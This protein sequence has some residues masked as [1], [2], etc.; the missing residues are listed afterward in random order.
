MAT[1]FNNKT[2]MNKPL[3]VGSNKLG[4]LPLDARTRIETIDEMSMITFPYV[5]MMVYVK[6]EDKFYVVK[7]LK[8]EEIV[9]GIAATFTENYKIDQYEEFTSGASLDEEIIEILEILDKDAIESLGVPYKEATPEIPG[10]AIPEHY[11]KVTQGTPDSKQVVPDDYLYYNENLHV[12]QSDA[13]AKANP[14]ESFNVDDYVYLVG[15]VEGTETIPAQPEQEATG[16]FKTVMEMAAEASV[17]STDINVYGV[18]EIGGVKDGDVFAMGSTLEDVLKQ[19]FQ[20]IPTVEYQQPEIIL[21]LDPE[22]LE[23]EVGTEISPKINA[24]F[25]KHDAG[26]ETSRIYSPVNSQQQNSF[27]IIEGENSTSFGVTVNY[28]QGPQKTDTAGNNLGTPIQ[29]GYISASLNYVGYRNMFFGGDTNTSNSTNGDEVRALAK[30]VKKGEKEVIFKVPVGT[31]R[32]I[33]AYPTGLTLDSITYVEQGSDYTSLFANSSCMVGGEN[34]L[35]PIG[36]IVR[37]YNI[38]VALEGVM[39]FKVTFK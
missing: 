34:N 9:P 5:G 31:R 25:L 22:E 1:D 14:G 18:D 35:Y 21:S 32:V 26:D 20:K 2:L 38:P 8:G 37:I 16:L 3:F 27:T 6:D 7:S 30:K 10:T 11:E 39:T 15:A 12:Y 33:C 4:D 36:Y 23:Q 19:I 17:L 28:A 24:T 13:N 29:A